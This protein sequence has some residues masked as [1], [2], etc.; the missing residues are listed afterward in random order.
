M[1]DALR[2]AVICPADNRAWLCSLRFFDT[3]ST[4]TRW[5]VQVAHEVHHGT[6]SKD[7]ERMSGQLDTFKSEIK[8]DVC[9]HVNL[10]YAWVPQNIWVYCPLLKNHVVHGRCRHVIDALVLVQ[11]RRALA[12]TVSNQVTRMAVYR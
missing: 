7:A 2:F 1:K 3:R 4:W 5:N 6:V 11:S 9:I 8:H 12:R 10:T